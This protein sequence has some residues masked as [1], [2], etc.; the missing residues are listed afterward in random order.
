[1]TFSIIA[2]MDQSRRL[3]GFGVPEDA[4]RGGRILME[5]TRKNAIALCD[6][7]AG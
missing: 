3:S 6:V 2:S 5:A 1:M 4:G 7:S